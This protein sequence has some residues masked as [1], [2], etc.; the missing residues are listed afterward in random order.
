MSEYVDVKINNNTMKLFF[1]VDLK[2]V[3]RDVEPVF[4]TIDSVKAVAEERMHLTAP[5]FCSVKPFIKN[6][7]ILNQTLPD[8]NISLRNIKSIDY[9]QNYILFEDLLIFLD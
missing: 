2:N 8:S 5:I 9:I 4:Y 1:D 3:S 7:T 6:F